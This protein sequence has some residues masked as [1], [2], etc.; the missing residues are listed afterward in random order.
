[1]AQKAVVLYRL[2]QN[3]W[4]SLGAGFVSKEKK[5]RRRGRNPRPPNHHNT[6]PQHKLSLSFRIFRVFVHKSIKVLS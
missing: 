3:L 6:K 4:I 5:E 2:G 1:M